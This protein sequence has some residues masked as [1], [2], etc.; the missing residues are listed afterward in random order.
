[1]FWRI[2]RRLLWASRGRLT[3]ALLSVASGATVCAAL[4]NLDFDASDKFTRE[5]RALGANVIVAPP[6]LPGAAAAAG[7]QMDTQVMA[8]IAA[9]NAPEIVGAA[10]YVYVAAQVGEGADAVPVIVAGIWFDQVARMNSWWQV[11]GQWITDRNDA[12]RCMVGQDAAQ[13]LNAQPGSKLTLHYAGR[14][15]TFTVAGVVT[16][17]GSEDSQVFV[18]LAAAQSLAGL[19]DHA[20]LAQVSVRGTAP[21]VEAVMRRLTAALPELEVRP[22]RQLSAAEG[23]L[24]E[25]IRGLLFATVLLVLTLSALGVLAATAG[26]AI[27]RRRDVG[28]MKA[29]GGPVRRVM[30]FFLAETLLVAVAGGVFGGVAGLL[31]SQRIGL[32]VFAT[33]IT[34]RFVVL[35][36]TVA[37]M[38][39]VALAGALPL[40]L[41]GRV[42]PAEIL[43]GE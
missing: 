29:I 10:P 2:L 38:I 24:L 31:L 30:R 5:F 23:P 4:V 21:V 41:L 13:K 43:R 32:R 9:L 35:P 42:R 17:G 12:A 19:G 6:P 14:D 20:A 7:A 37:V 28:L 40:R 26:L 1:M 11:A 39:A 16:A 18:S 22:V 8:R 34:P 3:L 15:A 36:L 25:H 33:A 27:E